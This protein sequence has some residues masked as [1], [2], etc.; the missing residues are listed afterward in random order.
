[1]GKTAYSLSVDQVP[2]SAQDETAIDFFLSQLKSLKQ[3][4]L[5]IPL[6]DKLAVRWGLCQSSLRRRGS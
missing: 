5:P 1:M 4:Q 6:P 2:P 3:R